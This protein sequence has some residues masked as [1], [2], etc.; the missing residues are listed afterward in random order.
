MQGF[1][2]TGHAGY[3]EHGFDIICAG[4]SS[5]VQMA[6][7]GITDVVGAPAKI[8]CEDNLVA[9]ALETAHSDLSSIFMLEALYLQLSLLS[10]SYSENIELI[11]TEVRS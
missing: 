10:E 5:A 2:V 4:V 7:N 9:L 6:A 1:S 11:I 3:D 8:R